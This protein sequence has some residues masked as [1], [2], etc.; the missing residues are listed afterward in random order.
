MN[1]Y[2]LSRAL[3]AASLALGAIAPTH[4]VDLISGFGGPRDFGTEFLFRNDDSSTNEIALP[5]TVNFFG[6]EY[7]SFYLN[8]NGNITFG[9]ELGTYT[10]EPFPLSASGGELPRIPIIAPYWADVDTRADPGDNSNL[11]WVH[12]PNANTVV[13]TWD[14]VGYFSEHNDKRNDF[15]L[16]LRNRPETG[17]GN[18]DI[19]FR[20]RK[21][22]WTTGDASSGTNGLGGTPA[23]AGFDAGDGIH[24]LML[25]GSR[26][27]TVLDLVN[28]SNVASDTPGLWTFA[29][30]NGALPDGATASNP[31]MP[32]VTEAGWVFNFGVEAGQRVF[33]DPDIAVGYDFIV[34]SGPNI[35][36]ILLPA[37]GDGQYA[38]WLWNGTEWVDSGEVL[39]AG[40]EHVFLTGQQRIRI[41]GIEVAANLDPNDTSAFVTGLT[42]DG[43]GTVAMRQVAVT[44]AV[45]EPGTWAMLGLGLAVL[46][47]GTRRRRQ[48]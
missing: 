8:N 27:E 15:Q 28:T 11:A 21:L 45:P 48:R 16:V 4:A 43:A 39:M 17:A 33:V 38:L 32:V 7:G 35:A 30:R 12:S 46:A 44:V 42:F 9:A 18:F 10:P 36:S 37:V 13:V 14:S 3:A 34:D 23:Q 19:D 5:F 1:R 20:Y 31:L 47:T 41:L 24:F 40:L 26:T 22:Q 2:R 29:V 25:P 6:Q